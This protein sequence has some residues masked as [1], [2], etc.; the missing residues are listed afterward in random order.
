MS[1]RHLSALSREGTSGLSPTNCRA[2]VGD[3]DDHPGARGWPWR[4]L[5]GWRPTRK[6]PQ[7]RL[8]DVAQALGQKAQMEARGPFRILGRIVCGDNGTSFTTDP[9]PCSISSFS[10]LTR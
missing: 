4:R 1:T 5:A 10:S 3:G 7:Q 2:G 6:S 9:A 8:A